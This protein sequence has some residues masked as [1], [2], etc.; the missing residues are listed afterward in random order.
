MV[1]SSR[2]KGSLLVFFRVSL[3]GRSWERAFYFLSVSTSWWFLFSPRRGTV[4]SS[5][6]EAFF[7]FSFNFDGIAAAVL[8]S[9]RWA[10]AEEAYGGKRGRKTRREPEQWD[11]L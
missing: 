1:L 11:G 3:T 2:N 4:G 9:A 8:G 6:A 7:F 10:A 5:L